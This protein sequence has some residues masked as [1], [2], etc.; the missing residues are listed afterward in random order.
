MA[1][2][3]SIIICGDFRTFGAVF[4]LEKLGL[5]GLFIGNILA[6]TVVPFSSDALYI[7]VLAAIKEPVA[8][9]V[10]GTLGNWIGSLIT[11]FVGRIGKWEWLEKWFKVKPETLE[12]QKAK[13]DKYGVWLALIAWVPIVG[14]VFVLALGFY[15]TPP[16]WTALL[17]LVGKAVRFI[18]WTLIFGMF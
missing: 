18:A 12:K 1:Q 3:R 10:V 6:A 9:L 13:V 5:L 14:D 8:C 11:Y 15:R 17:L 2:G 7:A 16:G 4:G